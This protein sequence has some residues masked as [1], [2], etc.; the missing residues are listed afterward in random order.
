M[1]K[2]NSLLHAIYEPGPVPSREEIEAAIRESVAD[3]L[4]TAEQPG[5]LLSGGVDSGFLL[6]QVMQYRSIPTFTVAG[7]HNHPDLLAAQRLAREWRN[8][9]YA[10][11]PDAKDIERARAIVK[12]RGSS[13]PGDEAVYLACEF[14]ARNGVK[15]LMATDGIDELAGGYWWHANPSDRFP[16]FSA[17]FDYFWQALWP[18]HLEPLLKSAKACGLEVAFPY[19]DERVVGLWVRVPLEQRVSPGVPKAM[20]KEMVS[21]HIPQWVIR[22]PKLG[23]VSA[24][25]WG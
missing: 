1:Q 11:V 16:T 24:L 25:T 6:Y 23:F 7:G 8:K 13:Y 10:W 19:L 12:V 14:A 17:T 9:H 4:N 3:A 2:M 15:T 5:L 21:G 18:E 20:W 22:R